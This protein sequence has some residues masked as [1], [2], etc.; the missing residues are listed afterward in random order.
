[1]WVFHTVISRGFIEGY[2]CR[3]RVLLVDVLYGISDEME[4]GVNNSARYTAT[5]ICGNE[6]REHRH[7]TYKAA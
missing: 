1:M 7:P 3:R 4:V 2:D 5:L 6:P